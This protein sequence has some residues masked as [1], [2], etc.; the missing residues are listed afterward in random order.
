[1]ENFI[2]CAVIVI[3]EWYILA[4]IYVRDFKDFLMIFYFLACLLIFMWP[5][6]IFCDILLKYHMFF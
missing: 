1:M 5:F 6:E 3:I 2:F 4:K